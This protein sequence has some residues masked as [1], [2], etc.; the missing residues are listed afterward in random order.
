MVSS[1]P[2]SQSFTVRMGS[3]IARSTSPAVSAAERFCAESKT[4]TSAFT[5]LASQ[6]PSFSATHM[7]RMSSVGMVPILIEDEPDACPPPQPLRLTAAI[8]ANAAAL[9]RND[10]REISLCIDPPKTRWY[11]KLA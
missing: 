10:L 6:S 1:V 4:T 5:L 7:G 9:A 3:V 11:R 8:A 2:D